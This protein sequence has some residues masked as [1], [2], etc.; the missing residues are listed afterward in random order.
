MKNKNKVS[1]KEDI[2]IV[3]GVKVGKIQ[4]DMPEIKYTVNKYKS[5]YFW[6][7]IHGT[8]YKQKLSWFYRISDF[9]RLVKHYLT[10]MSWEEFLTVNSLDRETCTNHVQT[11]DKRYT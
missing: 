7:L 10:L 4:D 6:V 11:V 3:N 5:F 2:L 9:K 8:Y 1:F